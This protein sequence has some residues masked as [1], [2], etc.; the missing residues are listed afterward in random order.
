MAYGRIQRTLGHSTPSLPPQT[1][2]S[3]HLYYDRPLSTL[4]RDS[5][6]NND[7]ISGVLSPSISEPT[8]NIHGE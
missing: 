1:D 7:L 8:L 2:P 5:C 3:Y 6:G 4:T